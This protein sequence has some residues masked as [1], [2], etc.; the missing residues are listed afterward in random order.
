MM[1]YYG[2]GTQWWMW[3]VSFAMMLL[4]WGGLA[5]LVV[6][7][8]NAFTHQ[9]RSQESADDILRRRLAAGQISQED[10]EKTRRALRG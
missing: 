8:V 2:F 7:A 6:W 1:G 9:G 5:L 4:F 10:Y 3:L